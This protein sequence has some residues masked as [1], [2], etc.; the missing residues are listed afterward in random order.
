MSV[1][2]K[3]VTIRYN[4]QRRYTFLVCNFRVCAG[5]EKLSHNG[6]MP[7][8]NYILLS[9]DEARSGKIKLNI[10]CD[11]Q[12]CPPHLIFSLQVGLAI[13]QAL[14]YVE[15]CRRGGCYLKRSSIVL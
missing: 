4:V 1:I 11:H 7:G 5:V 6:L 15:G 14:D 9:L 12:R 10:T 13:Q 3:S 2:N 8:T